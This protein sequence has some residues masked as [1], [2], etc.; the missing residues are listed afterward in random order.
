MKTSEI[1]KK[2]AQKEGYDPEIALKAASLQIRKQ[3]LMPV[4]FKDSVMFFKPLADG[5]GYVYF[6]TADSPLNA[7]GAFKHFKRNLDK[8]G[9]HT[10]YL[11]RQN[12]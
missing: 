11:D 4:Q 6:L 12:P 2:A 9:I 7:L 10:V 5:V 1:I 3:G 8:S